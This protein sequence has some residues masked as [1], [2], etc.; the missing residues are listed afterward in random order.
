LIRFGELPRSE[1]LLIEAVAVLKTIPDYYVLQFALTDL[2]MCR[3]FQ[4]KLDEACDAIN[5]ADLLIR[6]HSL[7]GWVNSFVRNT[8]AEISLLKADRLKGTQRLRE[9][10]KVGKSCRA[11]L[12]VNRRFKL[13]EARSCRLMGTFCWLKGRESQAQNWWKKALTIAEAQGARHEEGLIYYE[14]GKRMKNPDFLKKAEQ[15]FE[16][17]GAALDLQRVQSETAPESPTSS[18]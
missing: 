15:I 6:E 4:G 11:A 1:K 3:A 7:K 12:R 10:G 9:S 13:G 8:H 17:L 5:E 16:Q 14:K 18:N 2:A